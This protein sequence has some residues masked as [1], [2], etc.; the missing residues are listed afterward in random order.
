MLGLSNWLSSAV[1]QSPDEPLFHQTLGTVLMRQ[2][3][4]VEAIGEL[5]QSLRGAI[6]EGTVHEK[7]AIAYQ[8]I[9]NGTQSLIH[10]NLATKRKPK[11]A[12]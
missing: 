7:L 8:K 2:E 3:K 5:E 10:A 6:D 9:G 11:Q 12:D 4:F 1:E